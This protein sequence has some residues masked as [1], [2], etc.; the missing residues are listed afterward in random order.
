MPLYLALGV[1]APGQDDYGLGLLLG[2]NSVTVQLGGGI[3]LS[4]RALGY[5]IV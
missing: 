5:S 2:L 1:R 3:R 4:F